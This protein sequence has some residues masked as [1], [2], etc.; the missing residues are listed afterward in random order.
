MNY[1]VDTDVVANAL[2]GRAEEVTL[3]TNLSPQGLAISL[4]TY[5]EIYDGIYYGRDPQ[6]NE[7][8]FQQFLRWVDVLPLNRPLMRQFARIRGYLRRSGQSIPDPDLLIAATAIHHNLMVVTH[9]TRHFSRIPN[10]TLYP[11]R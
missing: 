4:I 8:I 3:L 7:L 1:L 6:A 10:L 9:N 2:K 11:T 5:G